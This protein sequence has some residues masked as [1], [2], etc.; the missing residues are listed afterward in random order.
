SSIRCF[1]CLFCSA[2]LLFQENYT[3]KQ[4]QCASGKVFNHRFSNGDGLFAPCFAARTRSK[5][6][7]STSRRE[8]PY[9]RRDNSAMA[10]LMAKP[11]PSSQA[12]LFME[13][14]LSV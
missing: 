12:A 9:L 4:I 3:T 5:I 8:R 14:G 13:N 10:F 11:C 1:C 7:C 6:S 2:S